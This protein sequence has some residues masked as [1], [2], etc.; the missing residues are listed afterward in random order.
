MSGNEKNDK[1]DYDKY[2]IMSPKHLKMSKSPKNVLCYEFP[3]IVLIN[4]LAYGMGISL[5]L[6]EL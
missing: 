5:I 3:D 1:C 2:R 6:T 4:L